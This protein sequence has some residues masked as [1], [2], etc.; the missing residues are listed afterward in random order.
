[1]ADNDAA[2]EERLLMEAANSFAKQWDAEIEQKAFLEKLVQQYDLKIPSVPTLKK[3]AKNP[4]AILDSSALTQKFILT[5]GKHGIHSN[6]D[7]LTIYQTLTKMMNTSRH[8]QNVL[9]DWY[10]KYTAYRRGRDE[11]I[12]GSIVID[13]KGRVPWFHHLSLQKVGKDDAR[14]FD[15]EGPVIVVGDRIY[16]LGIG[17]DYLRQMT[18]RAVARPNEE[19]IPGIVLT[20]RWYDDKLAPLAAK[21]VLFCDGISPA[22]GAIESYLTNDTELEGVIYGW[23]KS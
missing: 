19:A 13:R 23:R 3:L 8:R 18:L 16:L 12:V 21:T 10:G 5:F 7:Y 6:F 11:Y 15:H 4:E 1:M 22:A 9:E 14:R 2:T 17:K 20:E